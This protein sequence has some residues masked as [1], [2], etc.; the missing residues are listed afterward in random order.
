MKKSNKQINSKQI[1]PYI[2]EALNFLIEMGA[3]SYC[4]TFLKKV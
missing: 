1:L 3:P 2:K 4:N